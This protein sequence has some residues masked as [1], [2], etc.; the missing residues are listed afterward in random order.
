MFGEVVDKVLG[1]NNVLSKKD[2][3]KLIDEKIKIAEDR[4]E[5]EAS[6]S[7]GNKGNKKS[8]F[9][10]DFRVLICLISF[11]NLYFFVAGIFC[12]ACLHMSGR[13]GGH[14]K[15]EDNTQCSAS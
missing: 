12:H 2:A 5:H 15:G 8:H 11:R 13:F 1:E 3:W 4:K 10:L 9:W 7:M 6:G 14:S